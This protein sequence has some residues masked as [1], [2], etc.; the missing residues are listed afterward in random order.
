MKMIFNLIDFLIP[1]EIF[2]QSV[3]HI[4]R[5]RNYVVMNLF[6]MTATAIFAFRNKDLIESKTIHLQW[7]SV[8]ISICAYLIFRRTRNHVFSMNLII[9]SIFLVMMIGNM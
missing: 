8:I 3:D 9:G 1:K 7:L 2:E 4:S 6:A 5:V